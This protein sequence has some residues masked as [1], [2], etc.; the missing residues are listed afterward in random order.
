[1]K[2]TRSV[3]AIVMTVVCAAACGYEATAQPLTD[4]IAVAARHQAA[5][6]GPIRIS[7]SE[8][9][10]LPD[11]LQVIA[12]S[13]QF[14]ET[15]YAVFYPDT[16]RPTLFLYL[17][18]YDIATQFVYTALMDSVIQAGS[19]FTIVIPESAPEW[20]DAVEING[21]QVRFGFTVIE[22]VDSDLPDA[23]E[24]DIRVHP[25]PATGQTRVEFD[26]RHPVEAEVQVV[27]LLGR[28]ITRDGFHATMGANERD[29]NL[30]GLAPGVYF[31]RLSTRD[32]RSYA[33][34]TVAI[35][36]R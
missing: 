22:S 3:V 23:I 8:G 12:D 6:A 32:G 27:D 14:G 29:V 31:V 16:S 18:E 30:H 19:D 4:S 2:D 36:V 5:D 10:G 17:Y 21:A 11:S 24:G 28:V 1:M 15:V 26:A 13:L 20:L 9:A 34:R 35:A 25:N 7:F 33:E